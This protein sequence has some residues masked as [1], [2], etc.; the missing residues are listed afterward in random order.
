MAKSLFVGGTYISAGKKSSI[1]EKVFESLKLN[2]IDYHNGGKFNELVNLREKINKGDYERVFWFPY[3]EEEN[4][5]I[6]RSLKKRNNNFVLISSQRNLENKLNFLE[7]INRSLINKSNL[8]IEFS[9]NENKYNARIID[10]LGNVYANTT[11]M[12]I[13]GKVLK[14]RSDELLKYHRINSSRVGDKIIPQANQEFLDIIR[15]Y[16]EIFHNIIYGTVKN[17]RF[18]G[19]ASFR[20][21]YGF[22]SFRNKELIF[23]SERNIDKRGINNDSFVALN[24]KLPIEYY[25]IKKP[26]VDSPI[27][28]RLYDYYKNVSF[29][30][31]SHTYLSNF[32]F[33]R[34][35]VPCGAL[36][37]FDEIKEL[38]ND[39][40]SV[41]FGVNLKGHGSL[42]L[43]SRPQYFHIFNYV[44]RIVPE[45]WEKIYAN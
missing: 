42:V 6:T 28:I 41:N 19:N 2:E 32:P 8:H 9:F 20:C 22:P 7:I 34:N 35:L 38:F 26:S 4:T 14:T 15:K 29:I 25:G 44:K 30:M 40:K 13:I 27:Q 16:G 43:V 24:P 21:K 17:E 3:I 10:P 11:D 45:S 31:H 12:Q 1:G 18:M 5:W 36:E 37:E 33:T 23:V 39:E